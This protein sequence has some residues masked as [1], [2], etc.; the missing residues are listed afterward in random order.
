MLIEKLKQLN[1]LLFLLNKQELSNNL[2][3][4][5]NKFLKEKVFKSVVGTHNRSVEQD[6][7]YSDKRH[8]ASGSPEEQKPFKLTAD[9]ALEFGGAVFRL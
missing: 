9:F 2:N 5:Q 8:I 1:P 7:Y 6:K 4:R 3:I